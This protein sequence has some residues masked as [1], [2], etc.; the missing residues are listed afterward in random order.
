MSETLDRVDRQLLQALQQDARSTIA[1]LSAA[2]GAST[3]SVN[4]RLKRLR[5]T[6]LIQKEV[7]VLSPE[8]SDRQMRT[9]ISVEVERE[10]LDQLDAFRRRARAEP[11]IQQCYC[12]TGTADYILI[13]LTR[14]MADFEAFTHRFF[15]E[16]GNV[17][18]YT[19]NVVITTD[20]LT[21]D[22]P[23]DT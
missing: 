3:A 21:L 23:L 13:V 5:D 11:R 9:I 17:R 16:A 2:V 8:V 4:R 12:V 14:D 20:K 15:F 6:G 22:I 10:S 1:E 19:T 18:R 7:A